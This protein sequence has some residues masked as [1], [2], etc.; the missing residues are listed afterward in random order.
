MP[1]FSLD[2]FINAERVQTVGAGRQLVGGSAV[3]GQVPAAIDELLSQAHYREAADGIAAEMAALPDV[4]SMVP[5]L[6]GLRG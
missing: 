4:A 3:I 6:A 5:I 1:L 2:Q